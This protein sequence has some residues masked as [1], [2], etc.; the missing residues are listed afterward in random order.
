MNRPHEQ[1]L[2]LVFDKAEDALLSLHQAAQILGVAYPTMVNYN[3]NNRIRSIHKGSRHFI[4]V[5]ELKRFSKY[6]NYDPNSPTLAEQEI[7]D[8]TLSRLSTPASEIEHPTFSPSPSPSSLP[9]TEE[10]N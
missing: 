4:M 10:S 7:P 9:P 6:G 2:G 1:V 8:T 3:K 5:S